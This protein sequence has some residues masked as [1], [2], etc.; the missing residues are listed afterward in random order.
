[1]RQA[2]TARAGMAEEATVEVAAGRMARWRWRGKG[3]VGEKAEEE[4]AAEGRVAAETVASC[5]DVLSWLSKKP[6]EASTCD[7]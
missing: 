7:H 5:G 6:K 4:R 1:M 3:S 2:E